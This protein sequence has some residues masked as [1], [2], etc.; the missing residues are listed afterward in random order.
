MPVCECLPK[1]LFFQ[2]K[3]PN[4]PA[5]AELLKQRLCLGDNKMCA[6]YQ[7]RSVL[8][9]SGV[10]TDLFPNQTDKARALL[11]H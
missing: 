7:V 1:C 9:P 2:D 11:M 4:K 10:P 3:M 5:S 6:R 8:G